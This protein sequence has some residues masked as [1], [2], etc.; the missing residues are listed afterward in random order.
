M[1]IFKKNLDK[2]H[3]SKCQIMYQVLHIKGIELNYILIKLEVNPNFPVL[4]RDVV[5]KENKMFSYL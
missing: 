2:L 1:L 5:Y 4:I 3:F